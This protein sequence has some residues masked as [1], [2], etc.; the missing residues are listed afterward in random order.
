[1]KTKELI[2]E[3]RH[4]ATMYADEPACFSVCGP[5]KEAAD[6]LGAIL[7]AWETWN[8]STNI[9]KRHR[10]FIALQHAITGE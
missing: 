5:L 2:E 8:G 10:L 3:L 4:D 9:A 7:K 1:M 6:R